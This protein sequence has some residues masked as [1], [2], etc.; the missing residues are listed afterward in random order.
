MS[1]SDS[2]NTIH[3]TDADILYSGAPARE[4]MDAIST[5]FNK[6]VT[7]SGRASRSE[8]WFFFLFMLIVEI[9]AAIVDAIVFGIDSDS[10][11]FA[12]LAYL[13]LFLPGFAAQF[14]RLHDTG[15]SGWWTGIFWLGLPVWGLILLWMLENGSPVSGFDLFWTVERDLPDNT[16]WLIGGSMIGVYFLVILIFLCQRGDLVK[17]R[18]G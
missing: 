3:N 6:Y 12:P 18:F 11:F 9:V 7:F 4:F 17:N 16:G 14:R 10:S 1:D 13:V 5:C 8:Y 2:T 15:R